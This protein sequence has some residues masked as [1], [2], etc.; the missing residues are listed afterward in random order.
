MHDR[1]SGHVPMQLIKENMD[2]QL[3]CCDEA[4]F[5][6]LGPLTRISRR[7]TTTSPRVSARR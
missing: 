3:E 6:T 2:K 1:R 5:Y 7:A 4:P